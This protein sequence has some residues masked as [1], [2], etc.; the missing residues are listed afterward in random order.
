[1]K[2]FCEPSNMCKDNINYVKKAGI[3]VSNRVAV[4]KLKLQKQDAA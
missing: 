4:P 2:R 1:M 3:F